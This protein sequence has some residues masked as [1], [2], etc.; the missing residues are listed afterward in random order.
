MK[1]TTEQIIQFIEKDIVPP[2]WEWESAIESAMNDEEETAAD[3]ARFLEKLEPGRTWS[4]AEYH[5]LMRHHLTGRWESA[6]II[7][8]MRAGEEQ[9][10]ALEKYEGNES[11]TIRV[12]SV[13]AQRTA[14]DEAAEQWIRG[15]V[16]TMVFDCADGTVLTFDGILNGQITEED[17]S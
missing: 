14:S 9:E 4:A 2:W 10:D 6:A 1:L 12:K 16:G 8:H 3:G 7:G 17:P 15:R 5:G 11:E 13:Y